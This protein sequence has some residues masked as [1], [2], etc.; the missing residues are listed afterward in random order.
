MSTMASLTPHQ[1]RVVVEK[2]ELDEKIAR[3]TEFVT[4]SQIFH[5]LTGH[6]QDLLTL[7]LT[8]MEQY[9][10]ILGRRLALWGVV[11]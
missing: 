6:E 3:L 5:S 2:R 7:Q 10:T 1:Q 4:S 9:A 11:A 8:T